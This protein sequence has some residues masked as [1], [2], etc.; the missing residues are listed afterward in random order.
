M[1]DRIRQQNIQKLLNNK[2][3]YKGCPF[4]H[5]MYG[6]CGR[7]LEV[8]RRVDYFYEEVSHKLCKGKDLVI[9][10][11]GHCNGKKRLYFG[12]CDLNCYFFWHK[13]FL[14]KIIHRSL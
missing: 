5:E 3:M 12:N 8:L 11:G 10:K 13:D 1:E 4:M 9:L 2:R 6:F 14:V 7:Q